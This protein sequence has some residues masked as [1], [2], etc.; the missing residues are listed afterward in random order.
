MIGAVVAGAAG[1]GTAGAE[2]HMPR[3]GLRNPTLICAGSGGLAFRLFHAV[4]VF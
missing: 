2:R 1:W 4:P 3:L